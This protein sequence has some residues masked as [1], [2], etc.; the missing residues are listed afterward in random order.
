[1]INVQSIYENMIN[2]INEDPFLYAELIEVL[3]QEEYERDYKKEYKNYHGKAK[4]REERSARTIAR[5]LMKKKGK[6]K[7]GDGKDIDHKRPLRSGGSKGLNNLR[8]RDKSSNRSD[9]GHKKGETQ[10]KDSWK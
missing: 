6:V 10:K 5:E 9:N 1:M 8:V 7:K 3:V 2:R 4:Q